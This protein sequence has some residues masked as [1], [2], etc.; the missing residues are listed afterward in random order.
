MTE[1]INAMKIIVEVTTS[2]GQERI[3]PKCEKG[4]LLAQLAGHKSLT[5]QDLAIIKELGYKVVVETPE[6]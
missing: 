3:Y 5:R 6:L 1:T 2:Y 4:H